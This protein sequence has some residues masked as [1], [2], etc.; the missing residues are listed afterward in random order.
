M[1]C[2]I[3]YKVIEVKDE[4]YKFLE[5]HHEVNNFLFKNL[6]RAELTTGDLSTGLICPDIEEYIRDHS[7]EE[8]SELI[9]KSIRAEMLVKD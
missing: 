2:M 9:E 1:K 4:H 6:L 7:S 8:L 5:R 3:D